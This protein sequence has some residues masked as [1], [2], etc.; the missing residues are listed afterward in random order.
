MADSEAVV[1]DIPELPTGIDWSYEVQSACTILADSHWSARRVLHQEDRE[2]I[3]IL[4]AL[5]SEALPREWVS[6][7]AETLGRLLV[8]LE[9]AATGARQDKELN[10]EKISPVKLIHA[11][12]PGR[13][14]KVIDITWLKEATKPNRLISKK[15]LAETLGVHQNTL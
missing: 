5:E 3:P 7:A 12:S 10:L 14:R 11:C 9:R 8:D 15:L 2:L 1:L 4:Q 6:S 13:P